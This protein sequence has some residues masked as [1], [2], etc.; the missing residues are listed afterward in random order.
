MREDLGYVR[1]PAGETLA[2]GALIGF[3]ISRRG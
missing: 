2:Q 1:D 3:H